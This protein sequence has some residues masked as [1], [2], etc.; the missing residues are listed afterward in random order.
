[1]LLENKV[2]VV[3]GAAQG[4][5]K[6]IATRLAEAKARLVIC[7][8]DEDMVK[9]TAQ[10][11]KDGYNVD[12][13][14][15]VTNV[16]DFEQCKAMIDNTVKEMGSVDILVNN[17]G[18]TRDQLLM[19]MKE[20]DWDSVLAINL[21]GTFNCCRAAVRQLLKQRQGRIINIS[22]V[23]GV[24]GNAGQINYAASKAGVIG[25][26]KS[27]AKEM[28]SRG[29]TVN[30]VAPGFIK[31]RM[32]DAMPE[33]AKEVI[34]KQIPLQRLGEPEDVANVVLFLA[35]EMAGYITGEVIKVDGGLVM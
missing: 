31:T 5:G 28:A 22:S 6:A 13:V 35:S 32:T 23:V 25:L 7:D 12:C 3:T 34:E 4:I 14:G 29:V 26:T 27:L 17:A 24:M 30:A 10:E 20:E 9:A 15:V 18:I 2:A 1:M 11:I 8:I 33:A 19:R 21:K 16:V